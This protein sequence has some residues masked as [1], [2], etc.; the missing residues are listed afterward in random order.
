M[1]TRL[2]GAVLAALALLP[3]TAQ[4]AALAPLKPCYVSVTQPTGSKMTE[5]LDVVE[6]AREADEGRR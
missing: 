5:T 2:V 1:T 6:A 4:A 3:A